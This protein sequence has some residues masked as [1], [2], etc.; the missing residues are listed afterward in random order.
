MCL[1]IAFFALGTFAAA[2]PITETFSFDDGGWL[3]GF[4][5]EQFRFARIGFDFVSTGNL[6]RLFDLYAP[7][8][9]VATETPTLDASGFVPSMDTVN[10]G[11]LQLHFDASP[12]NVIVV[13]GLGDGARLLDPMPIIGHT[14]SFDLTEPQNAFAIA[15]LQ[16]GVFVDTAFSVAVD[17]HM[18]SATL[19]IDDGRLPAAVPE[20]GSLLL[21]S[22]GLLGIGFVARRRLQG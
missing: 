9:P 4:S 12:T 18:L 3:I 7:W 15:A 8:L 17:L 21:L 14:L 19:T 5:D 6:A 10:S 2:A 13:T 16:D 22:T 20:P 1:L 11:I